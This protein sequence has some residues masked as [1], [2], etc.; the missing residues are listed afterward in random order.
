MYQEELLESEED[1]QP[2]HIAFIPSNEI[3]KILMIPDITERSRSYTLAFEKYI[4]STLVGYLQKSNF[5]Q[6]PHWQ[7]LDKYCYT[8]KDIVKN[9]FDALLVTSDPKVQ[10]E[11]YVL[12]SPNTKKTFFRYIIRDNGPGFSEQI[13]NNI[14]S[15]A[16]YGYT[17]EKKLDIHM[18]GYGNGLKIFLTSFNPNYSGLRNN[19]VQNGANVYFE[20]DALD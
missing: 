14:S 7:Y 5:Y 11:F 6:L 16:C 15:I 20:L 8:I 1:I 17:S 2:N 12:I 19:Q 10:M 13:L 18:G 4:R 9:S 3:L